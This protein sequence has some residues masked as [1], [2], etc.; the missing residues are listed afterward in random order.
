MPSPK[1]SP[2]QSPP[3]SGRKTASGNPALP[4]HSMTGYAVETVDL[5]HAQVIL[6]LR[7]VNSRFLDLSFRMGDDFRPLEPQFRERIAQAVQRGKMECRINLVPR[8]EAALPSALNAELMDKLHVLAQVVQ[9]RF[10]Q[11]RPLSV[12]EVMRWPGMMGETALDFETLQAAVLARLDAA[13]AQFNASRAREGDKLKAVLGERIVAMRALVERLRPRTPEI[14]A[15]FREKLNKR[16]EELLPN[17]PATLDQ[18]RLHQEVVLF[19]Q[20]I[21]VDEEMDRLLTHLDEVERILAAGGA[22]G[23]RLDFLMQELNR[24]ANTLG[25]KS[26][27]LD[28]TQTSVE[29]KVLI[30]QMREQ[31]QNIE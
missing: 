14:V 30:E 31:I 16:L 2:L 8:E 23:K 29:L 28:Y 7:A 19:A 18:D 11:A 1:K 22:V 5:P 25:S 26:A 12:A 27:S 21:D 15:A 3:S 24:E 9:A 13:L 6:E 4:L 17:P 20:K 10:P